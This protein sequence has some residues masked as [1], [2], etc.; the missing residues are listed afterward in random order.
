MEK[1]NIERFDDLDGSPATKTVTLALDDTTVKLDLNDANGAKLTKL[2]ALWLEKGTPVKTGSVSAVKAAGLDATA[3]R[4]WAQAKGLQVSDRGRI[5]TE[6]L[7][8][9]TA[10]QAPAS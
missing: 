3:I 5:S 2:L 8:A 9:Y 10:D 7:V 6:L 4:A 1:I